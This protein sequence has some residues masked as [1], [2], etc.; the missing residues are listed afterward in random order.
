MLRIAEETEDSVLDR[1]LIVPGVEAL[2]ADPAKGRYWLATD[3]DRVANVVLR[4]MPTPGPLRVVGERQV[5]R[6]KAAGAVA[7]NEA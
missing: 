5:K 6:V 3:A 2:L 7:L 1:A 4:F